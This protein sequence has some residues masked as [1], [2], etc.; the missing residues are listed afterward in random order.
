MGDNVLKQ[1]IRKIQILDVFLVVSLGISLC[2]LVGNALKQG[3]YFKKLVM[4]STFLFSDFFYHIAGC[5]FSVGFSGFLSF[6]VY[7]HTERK[8]VSSCCNIIYPCMVMAG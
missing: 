1:R 6:Y 7:F 3:E 8:C 4:D 2:F 5:S